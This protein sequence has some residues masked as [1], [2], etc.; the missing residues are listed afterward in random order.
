MVPLLSSPRNVC[1][2]AMA[3]ARHWWREGVLYQLYP[4]S[5]A[6]SNGD[7]VGDLPG[8]IDRLD[9]LEWLG[10]DGIWLN[11][12]MPSPN[13]DWGYDVADYLGVHPE[14]GTLAD[15]DRLVSEA[16]ARGIR[17][18]LDLVP[19]H[20]STATHGSWRRAPHAA[21]P[22]ETGTSGPT[23]GPTGRR[24]TTGRASSTGRPGRSDPGTG[25][26]YLHQF[27]AEQPDL[28]WW[29]DAVREAFDEILRF[30]FT[31][32]IAG[33]RID[34]A[35]SIV[36]DPELR[37]LGIQPGVH[38]VHRRWRA[39]ADSEE[40][41][42]ILLGE[43]HIRELAQMIAFYGTGED[44]LHLAF[45]FPFVYAPFD[46]R[47]AQVVAETERLLPA[48][49]WPVWTGS[50]HDS[51]RFP[52]RW[53]EDDDARTRV[54]LMALLTLRGT[55]VLYY[56]DELGMAEVRSSRE[57]R[58]PCRPPALADPGR[59]RTRTPMQWSGAQGAGFT[60]AG[61]QPWLPLGDHRARNVEDQRADRGSILSFT[62]ELIALRHER[63]DLRT[64]AYER[65]AAPDGAWAWRRGDGFAVAVCLADGEATVDGV[66]G[67]WRS[68]RT[69]RATARRSTAPSGS[70]P[71]RAWW[72]SSPAAEHVRGGVIA[73]QVRDS[74]R[75]KS[76]RPRLGHLL[77]REQPLELGAAHARI[78]EPRVLEA[79][80]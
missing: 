48:K 4:R 41:R 29:N 38:D 24:P 65:I 78:A 44:E 36:K 40:P 35:H 66:R 54:A 57:Q 43:T 1:C 64:G 74:S 70:G 50:N 58:G 59:D 42:R 80:G 71:T 76:S 72:S 37:D 67:A 16:A 5:F 73:H 27:L 45:N 61:A 32:G 31:R 63:D 56:G 18:V 22:G 62:R 12:T 10:I 23:P 14:L 13:A 46:T 53:C 49:A 75:S 47:L 9:H 2:P 11:P 51:G 30:W 77:R 60:D 3:S 21:P 39:L 68:R 8:V 6:D 15:L 55:P 28:N 17:V 52:T 79:V 7:G 26:Y 25:Q 34:V 19:N 69:A 33:F 20:T